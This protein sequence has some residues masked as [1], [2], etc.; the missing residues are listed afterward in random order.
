MTDRN[1]K[2]LIGPLSAV[3][4]L[5]ALLV[6]IGVVTTMARSSNGDSSGA[7]TDLVAGGDRP[8]VQVE[9][10]FTRDPLNINVTLT[11]EGIEPEIIF[12]PAG[13]AIRLVLTNHGTKE[14]HFR[15][16]GL[17]PTQ[18]RWME[19]PEIDEYDVESM[20]PADLVAYG[21]E[22]AASIT[23]EA[24]L[25]HYMHHLVPSFVPSR[26]ESPTGIRPLGTEVHGWVGLGSNDL[27]EFFAL[28]TGEYIADD[29]RFPEHTARVIVFD[30]AGS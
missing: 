9:P 19:I 30:P 24:E 20:T 12:I 18:L 1:L 4:G 21:I 27:M 2:G 10:D 15:I 3:F 8:S 6:G 11:D 13:R 17:I 16:K 5:I 22:E 29:V 14:H 7:A 26:P 23:D 25:A 28:Q